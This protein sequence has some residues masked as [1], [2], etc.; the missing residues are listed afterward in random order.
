MPH[1]RRSPLHLTHNTPHNGLIRSIAWQPTSPD[2]TK[3]TGS[4][5]HDSDHRGRLDK[6]GRPRRRQPRRKKMGL[7][8]SFRIFT[9]PPGP[10]RLPPT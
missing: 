5:E 7:L 1:N 3:S 4:R 10:P 2:S 8:L 6:D 9:T